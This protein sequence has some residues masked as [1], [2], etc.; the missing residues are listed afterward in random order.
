M[1]VKAPHLGGAGLLLLS[2]LWGCCC[3]CD[4]SSDALLAVQAPRG[5]GVVRDKGHQQQEGQSLLRPQAQAGGLADAAEPHLPS[6]R[7]AESLEERACH[8]CSMGT[9]RQRLQD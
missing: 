7:A 6:A 5:G 4:A 9:T 1:T 2:Q 3:C 8:G